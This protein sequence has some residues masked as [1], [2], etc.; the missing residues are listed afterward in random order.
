M[1]INENEAILVEAL[2]LTKEG[3]KPKDA[4]HIACAV[5]IGCGYFLTTDDL[6]LKKMIKKN[7]ILI[8]NPTDFI[9]QLEQ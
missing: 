4:L 1:D 9:K 5:E 6:I 8:L 2:K 3:V 7:D